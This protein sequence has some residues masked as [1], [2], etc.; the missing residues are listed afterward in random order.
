MDFGNL[1]GRI[2]E[3]LVENIFHLAGYRVARIG[4]ERASD[5]SRRRR[6]RWGVVL[7]FRRHLA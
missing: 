6:A 7:L 2:A 4:R 5:A 1:K 3:A